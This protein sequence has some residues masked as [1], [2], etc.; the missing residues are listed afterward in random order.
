MFIYSTKLMKFSALKNSHFP[1]T[2]SIKVHRRALGLL[3][4]LIPCNR[5]ENSARESCNSYHLV[6]QRDNIS[7]REPTTGARIYDARMAQFAL[8][9]EKLSHIIGA[10]GSQDLRSPSL[11][12]APTHSVL[13]SEQIM[14]ADKYPSI[15]LRQVEAFVYLS[16]HYH[17]Q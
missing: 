5:C 17:Y 11:I 10:R 9:I 8:K 15:F 16:I 12:M 3:L 4:C 13:F 2:Q 14:F 7:T 1:Q 6:M